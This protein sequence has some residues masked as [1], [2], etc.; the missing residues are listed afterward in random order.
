VV[1]ASDAVV[2]PANGTPESP[3]NDTPARATPFTDVAC[4]QISPASQVDFW[5]FTPP[6]NAAHVGMH[7]SGA[8][9]LTITAGTDTITLPGNAPMPFHPGAPYIVSVHSASGN[10][11]P[12]TLTLQH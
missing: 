11:E 7:Y 10:P 2:C 5:T 12:Y 4:G 3:P 9:G 1:D 8:I 6:A